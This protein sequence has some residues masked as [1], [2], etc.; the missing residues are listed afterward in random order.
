MTT[1]YNPIPQGTAHTLETIKARCIEEGDCWLW[2]CGTSHGT[3]AIRH[4]GTI[5]YMRRYIVTELQGVV[6]PA[7]RLV[8]MCCGTKLCVNPDHIRVYTRAQLQ[9]YTAKRTDYGRDPVRNARI[10]AKRQA[11]SPLDWDRVREIR[12]M[13]GSDRAIARQ[14]GLNFSTIYEIRRN[15]TW[16]ETCN[17]WAGL[18]A[19]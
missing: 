12:S 9:T 18:L 15:I 7:R 10:A 4:N 16:R 13:E 1:R 19:A 14:L 6:I 17:P 3:P 11:Q 2:Q 8:S 5:V